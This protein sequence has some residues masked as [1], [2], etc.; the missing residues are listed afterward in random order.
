MIL[1]WLIFSFHIMS[2]DLYGT[3]CAPW[4]AVAVLDE[5]AWTR[6]SLC[7]IHV[8]QESASSFAGHV[9]RLEDPG[10]WTDSIDAS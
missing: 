7:E 9:L 3:I 10:G 8:P 2:F 6:N 1:N 5:S 4:N